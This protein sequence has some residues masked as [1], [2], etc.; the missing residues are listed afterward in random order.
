MSLKT[1]SRSLTPSDIRLAARQ[2]TLCEIE[3]Q[4]EEF[5][6]FGIMADWSKETTYR[7]LAIFQKMVENGLIYRHYRPVRFSPSSRSV[8]AEEELVYKD[9]HISHSVYVTFNLD[10]A[11]SGERYA[12]FGRD[13]KLLVWT[14]TPWT[15]TANMGIAVKPEL[16]YTFVEREDDEEGPLFLIATGQLGDP[17]RAH[18]LCSRKHP[19]CRQHPRSEPCF[20]NPSACPDQEFI[21]GCDLVGAYYKPIFSHGSSKNYQ[22][23]TCHV[24]VW[25]RFGLLGGAKSMLCHVGSEGEFKADVANVVGEAAVQSL[26]GNP[27]LEDGSRAVV[28]L[29]K[30]TNS[31]VKIER[32][33]HKYPYDQRTDEP[34][35]ATATFQ[36]FA[37]LNKIKDDAL[38]ALEHVE[39][40][41]PPSRL[42]SFIRSRSEW[43]ISHQRVWGLSIPALYH[44]PT[45]RAILDAASLSHIIPIP[46][47]KGI[48]YWWNGPFEEFIRPAL[49]EGEGADRE[50]RLG[51][52]FALRAPT[53]IGDSS[54]ALVSH[55]MVLD[56]K[57]KK[58]SKS[59][60]NVISSITVVAGG[61]DKKKELAYGADLLRLWIASVEYWNDEDVREHMDL[62]DRHMINEQQKCEAECAPAYVGYNF[63]KVNG[64]FATLQHDTPDVYI[65]LKKAD[66]NTFQEFD[67]SAI[68]LD[69][70][71]NS[72]GELPLSK[73]TGGYTLTRL[74]PE[75]I[76]NYL[77]LSPFGVDF[78]TAEK[79]NETAILWLSKFWEWL[80]EWKDKEVLL[81]MV[82]PFRLLPSKNGSLEFV[83]SGMFSGESSETLS[84]CSE[85]SQ[86]AST[87]SLLPLASDVVY[88]DGSNVDLAIL[89]PIEL[90]NGVPLSEIDI[91][92][93]ALKHFGEQSKFLQ[94]TFLEQ[95]V[96]QRDSLPPRLLKILQ[97]QGHLTK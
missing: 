83:R 82:S 1:D 9:D 36:W 80:G 53:S 71:S 88:L 6:Q 59:L 19:L 84:C 46:Q 57:G 33:K 27:V 31:L 32:F 26:V 23:F 40:F 20:P 87:S 52:M 24:R 64:K 45:D 16:A 72:T 5:Q 55:G 95:M 34:I 50:D 18:L 58:M 2:T 70:L 39:M 42:Q 25:H 63:P 30:E 79:S 28:A 78:S 47:E 56:Q 7:T 96:Q 60:G 89:S 12:K 76:V 14:T 51:L 54:K 43:R 21:V 68:P 77:R 66:F 65:L 15:L 13:I 61:K 62:A 49:W 48:E 73:G 8:L 37:N 22:S 3:T 75:H 17:Y 94:H 29:L 11:Q 90:E 86:T 44:I 10:A 35:N 81:S 38:S 69:K 93:L 85:C 74:M 4:K 92:T 41:P 91:V 97:T 67:G